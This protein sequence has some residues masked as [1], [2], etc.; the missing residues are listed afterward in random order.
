MRI[1]VIDDVFMNILRLRE[2][3]KDFCEVE[4]FQDAR[5]GLEALRSACQASTPYDVLFL[6]IVMPEM[7]G[8]EVL[9]AVVQ[10]GAHLP[11][12]R[13]TK[14][15]MVTARNQ[16]EVVRQAIRGGAAGY[17]IKPF[18]DEKIREVICQVK[19]RG[20]PACGE[21]GGPAVGGENHPEDNG[22]E[23]RTA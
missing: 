2:A 15:V 7:S 23:G 20:D 4:G 1:M 5:A 18:R 11:P 10:M 16:E 13:R 12:E 21:R 17:V 22:E 8:F 19:G 6:D 9:E 3:A 14:V